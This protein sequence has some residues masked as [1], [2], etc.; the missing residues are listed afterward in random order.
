MLG[1]AAGLLLHW[2]PWLR[3][4]AEPVLGSFYAVLATF[5]T[6]LK[7]LLLRLSPAGSLRE[8]VERR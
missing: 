8:P 1:F 3:A 7:W 5:A 4:A 2:L 6:A